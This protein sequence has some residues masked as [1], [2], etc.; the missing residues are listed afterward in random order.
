MYA[1][2]SAAGGQAAAYINRARAKINYSLPGFIIGSK[3][4][5]VWRDW[6][7]IIAID[8]KAHL[9]MYYLFFS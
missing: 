5:V 3:P 8:Y 2:L 4:G 1:I 6:K 9:C 7:V